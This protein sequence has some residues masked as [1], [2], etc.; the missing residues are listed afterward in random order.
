MSGASSNSKKAKAVFLDRDGVLN[1]AIVRE[2]RPYPPANLAELEVLPGVKQ[3]CNALKR[4][5]YLGIVVTN[6]P[7]IGRGTQTRELVD[8]MNGWLQTELNLDEVMVCP[9]DDS[10]QCECRKPAPGLIL[11]AAADWNID[12]AQ[13]FFVG[14]R[15]RDIEAGQRAG[16]QTIFIDYE[17]REKRPAAPDFIARNLSEAAEWIFANT[18]TSTSRATPGR[19]AAHEYAVQFER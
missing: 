7:D 16:C 10:A 3:A 17:Y 19:R 11:A 18:N 8:E 9:H 4:A 6:Q 2:G 5:G 12:L 13:S 1:R 14:D 15:W